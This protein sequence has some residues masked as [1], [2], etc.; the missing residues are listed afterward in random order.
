V[1]DLIVIAVVLLLGV[2]GGVCIGRDLL[3]RENRRL[4]RERDGLLAAEAERWRT[5]PGRITVGGPHAPP[6]RTP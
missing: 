3:A 5:D 1:L 2:S 6:R 4:R